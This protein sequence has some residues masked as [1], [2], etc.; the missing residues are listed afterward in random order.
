MCHV[1][2]PATLLLFA[3]SSSALD[4]SALNSA[5]LVLI[6]LNNAIPSKMP[7]PQQGH[8]LNKATPSTTPLTCFSRLMRSRRSQC[9][10][11]LRHTGGEAG[12]R[13]GRS[14]CRGGWQEWEGHRSVPPGCCSAL[15]ASR[16]PGRS[17]A[18][19]VATHLTE[20]ALTMRVSS[21]KAEVQMAMSLF[22]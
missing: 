13:A 19:E 11:V 7:P 5:T 9:M 18:A 15:I 12:S 14:W 17:G 6:G 21:T 8:P 3:L 1:C 10:T 2:Q 20:G 16:Q 4:G 22:T